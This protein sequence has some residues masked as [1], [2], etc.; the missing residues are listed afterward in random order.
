MGEPVRGEI[1]GGAL[2]CTLLV[3]DRE[4][5]GAG[6]LSGGGTYACRGNQSYRAL[7]LKQ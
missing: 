4:Q 5:E 7:N 1:H 6:V 2:V 3:G